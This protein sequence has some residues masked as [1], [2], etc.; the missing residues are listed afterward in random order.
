VVVVCIYLE[1]YS[2]A[3]SPAWCE[4]IRQTVVQ[5]W[6][7]PAATQNTDTHS[8]SH[9]QRSSLPVDYDN[10]DTYT[11]SGQFIQPV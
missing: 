3:Y 1:Y 4:G 11:Y 8:R 2:D 7:L 6:N 10:S 9:Q 5:W